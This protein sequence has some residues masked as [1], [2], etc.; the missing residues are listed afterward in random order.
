MNWGRDL[1]DKKIYS[2]FGGFASSGEFS[3][4]LLER[5]FPPKYL[6]PHSPKKDFKFIF[7]DSSTI[8]APLKFGQESNFPNKYSLKLKCDWA[9]WP[10]PSKL[11]GLAISEIVNLLC[12]YILN[13]CY[14]VVQSY[15]PFP[16][17]GT[18]GFVFSGLTWDIKRVKILDFPVLFRK[19]WAMFKQTLI[20]E[21]QNDWWAN[22]SSTI[23]LKGDW[24]KAIQT[25]HTE[26]K[27]QKFKCS[28]KLYE[29]FEPW[30]QALRPQG[31]AKDI[32]I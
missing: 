11:S 8:W 19:L 3:I 16:L 30:S 22:H 26:L 20:V 6:A 10:N 23:E 9:S 24:I 15:F 21:K 13:Y 25:T 14:S 4:H 12:C 1:V 18:I 17:L 32:F 28:C 7:I 29:P 31:T 5:I 27:G 2:S